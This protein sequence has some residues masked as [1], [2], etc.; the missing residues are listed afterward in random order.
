MWSARTCVH[1]VAGDH[2][3][4]NTCVIESHDFCVVTTLMLMQVLHIKL[5]VLIPSHFMSL[6]LLRKLSRIQQIVNFL[7]INLNKGGIHMKFRVLLFYILIKLTETSL[8]KTIAIFIILYY[9]FWW[10]CTWRIGIPFHSVGFTC[11]S[12][13]VNKNCGVESLDDSRYK[14]SDATVLVYIFL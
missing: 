3:V 7:I 9:R 13:T 2:T 1:V 12:L 4:K 6:R 8:D 14:F 5:L 11:T 10:V